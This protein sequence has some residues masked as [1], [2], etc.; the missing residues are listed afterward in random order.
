MDIYIITL[1]CSYK[2]SIDVKITQYDSL[3]F[4]AHWRCTSAR[5]YYRHYQEHL[6][7]LCNALT[8]TKMQR[9]NKLSEFM[10]SNST[11]FARKSCLYQY[12]SMDCMNRPY[13][14]CSK[15]TQC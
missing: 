9:N 7:Q 4:R 2:L 12:A 6:H 15:L 8:P 5:A 10:V 3:P 1:H 14:R 13:T 11:T